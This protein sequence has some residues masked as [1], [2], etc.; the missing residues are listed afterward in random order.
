MDNTKNELISST[1]NLK[2]NQPNSNEIKNILINNHPINTI[3]NRNH[4]QYSRKYNRYHNNI[5][6]SIFKNNKHYSARVIDEDR[7]K[8]LELMT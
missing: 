3:S 7:N 1:T 6:Y 2:N 5:N 8:N 4:K